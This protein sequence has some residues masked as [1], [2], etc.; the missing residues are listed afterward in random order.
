MLS[1][2]DEYVEIK[3]RKCFDNK[4]ITCEYDFNAYKSKYD[5]QMKLKLGAK[6]I[7]GFVF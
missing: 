4:L 5:K 1:I 3:M 2:E 7:L 6:R